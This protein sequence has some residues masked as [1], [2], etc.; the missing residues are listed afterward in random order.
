MMT[1]KQRVHAALNRQPADRVPIFMWYHPDTSARLAR[2]F[3]IPDDCVAEVM[4]DD[5]RQMWVSNNYDL[6]GRVLPHEGDRFTDVWGIEWVREDS[7]NQIIR[8]PLAQATPAEAVRYEFPWAHA[9]EL[10][11]RMESLMSEKKRSFI[12]CDVSPC[13]FEMYWRLRGME[14]GMMDL[15]MEPAMAKKSRGWARWM[16]TLGRGRR[17]ARRGVPPASSGRLGKIG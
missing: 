14:Q 17:L 6:A 4:G 8:S 2:V 3:E 1:P 15:A 10:L 13:V 12:G 11:A 16:A 7:F 9:D 5:I